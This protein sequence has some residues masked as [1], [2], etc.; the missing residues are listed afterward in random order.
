MTSAERLGTPTCQPDVAVEVIAGLRPRRGASDPEASPHF[1]TF[2]TKKWRNGVD[3]KRLACL[4][5]QPI[6]LL[7]AERW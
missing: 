7:E 4:R 5:Q 1:D 6:N 2:D 3:S